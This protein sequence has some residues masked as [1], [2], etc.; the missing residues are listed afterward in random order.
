MGTGG[1]LSHTHMGV[2]Q[3]YTEEENHPTHAA[4]QHFCPCLVAYL[5]IIFYQHGN[6]ASPHFTHIP[7]HYCHCHHHYLTA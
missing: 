7:T 5:L 6:M 1:F 3:H 2:I 4:S